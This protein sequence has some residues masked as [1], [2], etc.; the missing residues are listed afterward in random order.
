LQ[1]NCINSVVEFVARNGIY[2]QACIP[3]L[4]VQHS[5]AVY[6]LRLT[7]SSMAAV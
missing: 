6:F 5:F 3:L 7:W 2:F 1:F 4:A